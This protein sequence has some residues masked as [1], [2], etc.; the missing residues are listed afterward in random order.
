M[1]KRALV[2]LAVACTVALG[3]QNRADA[4]CSACL[5]DGINTDC[6]D[7]YFPR[8]GSCVCRLT[9]TA[10]TTLCRESGGGCVTGWF[11]QDGGIRDPQPTIIVLP[12]ATTDKAGVSRE[13]L[14]ALALEDGYVT[15]ANGAAML[16]VSYRGVIYL[17]V[18]TRGGA[19]LDF[20]T[21]GQGYVR[22]EAAKSCPT[23]TI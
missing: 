11:C 9:V 6:V 7:P 16:R 14:A 8:I 2:I 5:N 1:R 13:V 18:V 12:D 17:S 3:A 22:L 4:I 21:Q 19:V 20:A 23:P 15:A 10:T